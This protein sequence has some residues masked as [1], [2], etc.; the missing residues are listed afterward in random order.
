ML[1]SQGVPT[2]LEFGYADT[3][4][5]AWNTVWIND[6]WVRVDLTARITAAPFGSYETTAIY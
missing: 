1:R 4:Y 2:R 5:H 3:T 6:H